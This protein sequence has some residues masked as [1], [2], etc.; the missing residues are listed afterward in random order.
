MNE[1]IHQKM[2]VKNQLQS[3]IKNEEFYLTYLPK[4][5]V[6]NR[7]TGFEALLRWKNKKYGE[8]SPSKIIPLAEEIGIINQLGDWIIRTATE[9]VSLLNKSHE[10]PLKVTINISTKNYLQSDFV[11]N[12]LHILNDIHL[13]THYLEL[14]INESLIMQD[15]DYSM[16]IISKLKEHGIQIIIDNFGTGYSSLNFLN[17]FK[18]DYIKIAREFVKNI[19]T[20]FQH[21]ELV[22]AMIALSKKLNIKVIA[23]GIEHEEQHTLLSQLGCDQF[24]GYYIS[25]PLIAEKIPQFFKYYELHH[26]DPENK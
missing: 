22:T 7:I 16:K 20:N 10:L 1:E 18:V 8:I 5:D 25:H 24:Q 9:Q 19:M 4:I 15:P 14:E 3:A 12:I 6:N 13:P 17:Q 23:E 21:R 2:M 26:V 11:E